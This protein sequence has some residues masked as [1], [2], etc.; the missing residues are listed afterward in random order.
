MGRSTTV[1]RCGLLGSENPGMSSSEDRLEACPP[2]A[3]GF[4]S[5][6]NQGRVSRYPKVRAK[7]VADGKQVNIPAPARWRL[8]RDAGG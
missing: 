4:L 5:N 1:R 8:R 2:E 7:A 6:V 3:Q